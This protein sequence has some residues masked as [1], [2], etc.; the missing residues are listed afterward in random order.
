[1]AECTVRLMRN[2]HAENALYDLA[3]SEAEHLAEVIKSLNNGNLDPNLIETMQAALL[4]NPKTNLKTIVEKTNLM[5]EIDFQNL[6]DVSG[7]G[8]VEKHMPMAKDYIIDKCFNENLDLYSF[9]FRETDNSANLNKDVEFIGEFK[10]S[11]N[12]PLSKSEVTQDS[13]KIRSTSLQRYL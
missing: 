10:S 5:D 4:G 2:Q 9:I 8:Y 6:S 11:D 13:N 1:M 7:W 12:K 3:S